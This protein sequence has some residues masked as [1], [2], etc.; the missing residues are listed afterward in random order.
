MT[1]QLLA[2]ALMIFGPMPSPLH[3]GLQ[4]VG[5]EKAG[6]PEAA[7]AKPDSPPVRLVVF[8]NQIRVTE[9][10]FDDT[11]GHE[12]AEHVRV[13]RKEADGKVQLTVASDH[14]S[15]IDVE[16]SFSMG[17]DGSPK[18]DAAAHVRMSQGLGGEPQALPME[19]LGGTVYL[20][21][22]YPVRANPIIVKFALHGT[23]KGVSRIVMGAVK[24]SY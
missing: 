2:A 13:E 11:M 19:D 20:G 16:L 8:S 17:P 18:V 21:S 12:H 23:I 4:G 7:R 3:A 22:N 9:D 15:G 24:A 6:A 5:Q 1:L 14:D 10:W